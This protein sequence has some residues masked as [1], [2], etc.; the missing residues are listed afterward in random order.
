VRFR[1]ELKPKPQIR[2]SAAAWL[3]TALVARCGLG[4]PTLNRTIPPD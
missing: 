1:R 3:R 2:L 4:T